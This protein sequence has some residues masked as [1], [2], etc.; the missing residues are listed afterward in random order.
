MFHYDLLFGTVAHNI[1]HE[2]RGQAHK[3]RLKCI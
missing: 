2:H 3:L 1:F